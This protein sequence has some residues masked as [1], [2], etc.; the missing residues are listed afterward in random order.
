MIYTENT[1]WAVTAMEG[2]DNEKSRTI[3]YG[4]EL[5]VLEDYYDK[6]FGLIKK[7]N[8]DLVTQELVML[9]KALDFI[10]FSKKRLGISLDN[11]EASIELFEEVVDAIERGVIQD[12]LFSEDSSNIAKNM[13]AYLGFLIIANIGGKWKETENGTAVSVNGRNAYVYEYIE[14]RLLGISGTDAVSYYRSVKSAQ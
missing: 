12:E 5:Y 14:K 6:Q 9:G 7:G 10:R 11:S 8:I 3:D 2:P 13:S 4:S 1:V